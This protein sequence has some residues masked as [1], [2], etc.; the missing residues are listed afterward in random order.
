MKE[1]QHKQPTEEELSEILGKVFKVLVEVN[2]DLEKTGTGI[3]IEKIQFL[4]GEE[5]KETSDA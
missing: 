4:K 1:K 2:R 5:K 3:K